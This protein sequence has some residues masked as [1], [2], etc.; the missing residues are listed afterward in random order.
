M[1]HVLCNKVWQTGIWPQDWAHTVFVPLHK[2]GSTKLCSNY[3]LIAL[4]PHASKILLHILNERLKSYLSKEVAPEQAGF[5]K[6]KGT[7]EQILIVRQ[8]IEKS[9]E[10]NKA[11]YICFVDF[12]KAFD[13]VKWPVLWKT[14]LE[15]GTPKHLV[16]LLRR[17][18]EDGTASV[19]IDDQFSNHF[20]PKAGLTL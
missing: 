12:S 4:I 5:V 9:R 6:G 19:K 2:K 13:S 10:F 7:R 20:Q 1:F 14:L 3:R 18:Y 16:H 15:M 8:I 11:T 17:L